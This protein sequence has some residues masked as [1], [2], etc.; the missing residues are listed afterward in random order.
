MPV[1]LGWFWTW[2]KQHFCRHRAGWDVIAG[3]KGYT[4]ARCGK[5]RKSI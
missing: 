1:K 5:L 4:C 3:V 2:L